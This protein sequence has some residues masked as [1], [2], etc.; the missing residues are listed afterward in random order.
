MS[1]SFQNGNI[2]ER[3]REDGYEGK[4]DDQRAGRHPQPVRPQALPRLV[5]V[6][7]G[8]T[9]GPGLDPGGRHVELGDAAWTDHPGFPTN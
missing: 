8:G 5:P 6:A 4:N 3:R 2:E 9:P 7:L 1:Q